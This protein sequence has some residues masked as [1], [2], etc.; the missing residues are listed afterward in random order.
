[1]LLNTMTIKINTEYKFFAISTLLM[2]LVYG[3]IFFR[4][5]IHTANSFL[6]GY[7][8]AFFDFYAL[9][10]LVRRIFANATGWLYTPISFFRLILVAFILYAGF[11]Y[12]DANPIAL[13]VGVLIPTVAIF[14]GLVAG[15]LKQK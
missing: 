3:T 7:I 2:A 11:K 12:Y 9:A 4:F 5:G 10:R 15:L 6:I 1:M 14:I 8:V 13:A